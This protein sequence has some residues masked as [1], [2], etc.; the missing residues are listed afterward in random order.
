MG[1]GR[2]YLTMSKQYYVLKLFEPATP[3]FCSSDKIYIGTEDELRAVAIR[4]LETGDYCESAKAIF[5]YFRGNKAATHN[6]YR[7][8]PILEPVEYKSELTTQVGETVQEHLNCW[9]W[10]YVMRFDSGIIHQVI[11]KYEKKYYRC[12]RVWLKNLSYE[13]VSGHWEKL[14]DRFW[15]NAFVLDVTNGIGKDTTF[16][17]ILY[18]TEESYARLC[19]AVESLGKADLFK[20]KAIY[21]EVFGD[22]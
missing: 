16:N 20:F 4:M 7:E 8:I 11:I 1:V 12:T 6:L 15:G 18:V 21:D 5:E 10:P 3:G 9:Q 22:G 17:N 14:I 2:T 13:T 19:D